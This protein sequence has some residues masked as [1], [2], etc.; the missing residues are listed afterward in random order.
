MMYLIGLRQAG[1]APSNASYVRPQ[2]VKAEPRPETGHVD[3]AQS[4]Q[5]RNRNGEEGLI[6]IATPHHGI[7]PRGRACCNLLP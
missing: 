5:A 3:T 1:L 4:T 7:L 6:F 2:V